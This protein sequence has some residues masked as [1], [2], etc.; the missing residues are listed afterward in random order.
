MGF[1]CTVPIT[2]AIETRCSDFFIR[3]QVSI[4][5]AI[6]S[7]IGLRYRRYAAGRSKVY[8]ADFDMYF[9]HILGCRNIEKRRQATERSLDDESKAKSNGR[10]LEQV[11]NSIHSFQ[12][13]P[14][15]SLPQHTLMPAVQS[16]FGVHSVMT[17]AKRH[18][19]SPGTG[20]P[21]RLVRTY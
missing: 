9:R 3:R 5:N 7:G 13:S 20:C 17:A 10:F 14:S 21:A 18:I 4:C 8:I 16:R 15:P 11:L 19:R 1:A 12:C 2:F 6:A